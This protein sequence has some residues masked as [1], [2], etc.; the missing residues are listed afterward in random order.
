MSDNNENKNIEKDLIH[1]LAPKTL[2]K[3]TEEYEKI[4]PYLDRLDKSIRKDGINNIALSSGY[5]AGKS[6]ILNTFLSEY[7]RSENVLRISLASFNSKQAIENTSTRTDTDPLKQ[8]SKEEERLVEISVLQQIFY[9]VDPKEIPQSRFK[10]I[11]N[12]SID[13][14]FESIVFGIIWVLSIVLLLKY[15]YLDKLNPNGWNTEKCID[16]SAIII[17][18]ITFIGLLLNT[19]KLISFI[20][21]SKI[22]KLSIKG[23][24]ELG[25][26][27]SNSIF[28]T[29][30]D[31]IFYFFEA[32]EYDVLII[33]DLD[34]FN[35]IDVFSKLREINI[36][37]NNSKTIKRKITFI[38]A[39]G[40]ALFDDK[41]DR[42][43]FFEYIIPVIPFINANNASEQLK[44]MM[45][46]TG[47][48]ME[49]FSK[50]YIDNIALLMDDVDMRLLTNIFQEFLLY[51]E[52]LIRPNYDELLA[53]IIYKNLEPSDFSELLV[54]KGK[55]HSFLADKGSLISKILKEKD[56]RIKEKDNEIK[57]IDREQ[58]EN[59]KGLIAI[60]VSNIL[61]KCVSIKRLYLN[62]SYLEI[63]ELFTPEIL[64]FLKTTKTIT[65][66]NISGYS[67]TIDKSFKEIENEIDAK[68]SYDTRLQLIYKKSADEKNKLLNERDELI[69]E[70]SIIKKYSIKNILSEFG[71]LD[72]V[73]NYT[74]EFTDLRIFYYL[75][76]SGFLNE[77]YTEYIT[78]FY[79]VN[80]SY[81]DNELKKDIRTKKKTKEFNY[82]LTTANYLADHLQEDDFN[83]SA[84]L[85]YNLLDYLCSIKNNKFHWFINRLAL[86]KPTQLRTFLSGYLLDEER[87]FTDDFSFFIDAIFKRKPDLFDFICHEFRDDQKSLL[88]I[89]KLIVLYGDH[90]IF[91]KNSKHN[92][93]SIIEKMNGEFVYLIVNTEGLDYTGKI[94]AILEQLKPTFT[95]LYDN[96]K[97]DTKE[98]LLAKN[99]LEYIYI[100][101]MYE[102][103]NSNLVL[104]TKLFES[105]IDENLDFI[106]YT[107]LRDLNY[108]EQIKHI[109]DN[110]DVF[111]MNI[112]L[113]K[114]NTDESDD[115]I[116]ELL[117]EKTLS[118]ENKKKICNKFKVK[119]LDVSVIED[120][121]LL[122]YLMQER[123]I[124]N[125]WDNIFN[126]YEREGDNISALIHYLNIIEN[127]SDLGRVL[128]SNDKDENGKSLYSN[129]YIKI[130]LLKELKIE[131]IQELI[132][133]KRWSYK[134]ILLDELSEEKAVLLIKEKV[135][136][137]SVEIFESIQDFNKS[138]LPV[139]IDTYL[140]EI[141]NSI[142]NLDIYNE[143]LEYILKSTDLSTDT[144]ILFLEK[145]EDEI[146]E[147]DT[148]LMDIANCF[149]DQDILKVPHILVDLILFDERVQIEKR[150]AYFNIKDSSSL[151]LDFIKR[152][153][154]VLG[155]D[156]NKLLDNK[157]PKFPNEPIYIEFFQILKDR[158]VGKV[159]PKGDILQVY[160]KQKFI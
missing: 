90:Q 113:N 3:G 11:V 87:V 44:I 22:K 45:N 116:I 36:L 128:I 158:I 118:L 82:K 71:D 85:N 117:C 86:E 96:N 153:L 95:N 6:T 108:F 98:G 70:I 30:I 115:T 48:E 31:E 43:K 37:L 23:E 132:K 9:H 106:S 47:I 114:E 133:S 103:N 123:L 149:K 94:R 26:D 52:V 78:I 81:N 62:G 80:L 4:K 100:N 74:K 2:V 29:H 130:L 7:T 122:I 144:K 160:A 19:H 57:T 59:E 89:F 88:R 35:N 1:S 121:E 140:S 157:N 152:F 64:N 55:L 15:N 127:A 53:V 34:R 139:Y 126:I 41:K 91:L 148:V 107:T 111:V 63:H 8:S 120:E 154:K 58:I 69:G 135:V 49:K 151:S 131:S 99:V 77:K 38:Y 83:T 93:R 129:I 84:V 76:M 150:L 159:I 12:Y 92:Y 145:I 13:E 50:G 142:D 51:K 28:N 20:S 39:I 73:K 156:F 24:L 54:K 33:E 10:R 119:V 60:Y 141:S 136:A 147:D 25:D 32:T 138:L 5:G 79:G 109:R 97:L 14:N 42:V 56:N 104:L 21:N 101:N 102:L 146:N 61:E 17:S 137:F 65:F 46:S 18:V 72:Y 110:I 68:N 125:R 124:I 143:D 134:D 67:R 112:V 155:G 105:N 16:V 66:E 75:V 40:D 27:T